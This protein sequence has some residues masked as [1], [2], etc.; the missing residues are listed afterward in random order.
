MTSVYRLKTA[1]RTDERV[2]LMSEIINGMQVREY[3]FQIAS[4]LS[5]LFF[6]LGHKNVHLGNTIF[7]IGCYF[8]TSRS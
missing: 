1:I 7:E 6:F 3:F 5:N 2:R 8:E 4:P